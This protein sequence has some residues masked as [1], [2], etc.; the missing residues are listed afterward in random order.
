M[1]Y[2]IR[3]VPERDISYLKRNIPNAEVYLDTEH[4]GCIK[5]F[6]DALNYID[7]DCV[8]VQ[9][10]VL[11]CENFIEK[12]V[13][14]IMSHKSD[15]IIF[16]NMTLDKMCKDVTK[17]GYYTA[18][19]GF[20]QYCTYIPRDI[21][22]GFIRWINRR[23]FIGVPN[24]KRILESDMDDALFARYLDQYNEK[25][26]VVVPNL[27]GHDYTQESVVNKNRPKRKTEN[28]DY[29]RMAK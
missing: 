25:V 15:V 28:F 14:I 21:Q 18:R 27:A 16:C 8:F 23:D 4:E 10:D 17:S 7:D 29:E 6:I 5:S 11:L 19:K 3:A 2:L 24:I 13:G 26:Y 1:K 9:D 22:K 12:S 20:W